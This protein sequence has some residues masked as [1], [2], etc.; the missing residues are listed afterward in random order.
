MPPLLDA[1][2]DDLAPVLGS[3]AGPPAALEGGLTNHNYRVRLGGGEYVVRLPGADTEVLGIDRVAERAATEAAAAA[4][5]GP[6]VV[7]FERGC[8]VTRFIEGR[9][10][11][12]EEVRARL[13]A[14]AAALKAVH[15]GPPLPAGF[16]GFRVVEAYREATLAR[17]G[18]VPD[19]YDAAHAL[20][21]RIE[22]ALSGPEHRPVPCHDD[23]LAANLLWDGHRVRIVDWEY[24]G[25]G[26]R[27]FD[28]GNLAVNCAFDGDDERALLVAYF[29]EPPTARRLAALRLQRLMSDFREAMWGVLQGAVSAL[30]VDYGAYAREHFD[31]LEAAAADAPIDRWL[32]E[33]ARAA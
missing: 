9:P 22:A 29:G 30:D 31:R 12:P 33:A 27:Y 3:P 2:L 1:V 21:E 24:A 6:E 25:N 26:D 11:R 20:A 18:E 28:L 23:L 32:V 4:G 13:P 15:A 19:A 16:N 5:V 10:M 7:A 8:L 17:G 14:V